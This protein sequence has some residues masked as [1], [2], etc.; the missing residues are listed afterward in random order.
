MTYQDGVRLTQGLEM[1]MLLLSLTFIEDSYVTV[2][3][4]VVTSGPK[5]FSPQSH[6]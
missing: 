1:T 2:D 6:T 3:S 4:K 5:S